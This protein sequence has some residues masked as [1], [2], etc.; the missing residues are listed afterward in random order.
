M[1]PAHGRENIQKLLG[2]LGASGVIRNSAH[3]M[4]NPIIE[5]NGDTAT[6]RW[7]LIMVYTGIHPNGDLHYT[8]IIGWYKDTYVRQ[9]GEWLIQT[10][11]CQVEESAPYQLANPSAAG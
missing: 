1:G 4:M 8:R 10:L 3:N 5:V 6:G 7:R 11:F 2:D 9:N